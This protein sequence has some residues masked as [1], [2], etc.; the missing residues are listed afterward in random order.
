MGAWSHIRASE[1]R[2]LEGQLSDEAESRRL[3]GGVFRD[4]GACSGTRGRVQG[5][6]GEWPEVC[7]LT[8]ASFLVEGMGRVRGP[9]A[10]LP[11]PARGTL[12]PHVHPRPGKVG[13]RAP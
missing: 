4:A 5:R 12:L 7:V 8:Q 13:L 10:P 6:E 9:R 1:A 2:P 11:C 3:C